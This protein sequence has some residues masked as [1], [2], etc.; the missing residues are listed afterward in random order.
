MNLWADYHSE[1]FGFKTIE[2][3][4]GFICYG[5]KPPD[6]SIEEFY[7]SPEKRGTRTAKDLAD[8]VFRI[9]REAGCKKV[10]A[11]VQPGALGAEHAL[12]TNLHYGFKLVCNN[13]VDTIMV[14]NI[15][16]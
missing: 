14:K 8:L 16:E 4:G 2:V 11:K 7:V 10:W 15:E 12:R 1:R 9:A 6:A 3:E 13:G 5:L